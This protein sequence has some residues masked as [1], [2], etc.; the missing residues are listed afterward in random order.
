MAKKTTRGLNQSA[1]KRLSKKPRKLSLKQKVV[2]G[3][4]LTALIAGTSHFISK[5]QEKNGMEQKK[6]TPFESIESIESILESIPES[7][8]ESVP[9]SVGLQIASQSIPKQKTIVHSV[10]LPKPYIGI[11]KSEKVVDEIIKEQKLD[12]SGIRFISGEALDLMDTMTDELILEDLQQVLLGCTQSEKLH[13]QKTL[14]EDI[15][16]PITYNPLNGMWKCFNSKDKPRFVVKF[17]QR[18]IMN[19][20]NFETIFKKELMTRIGGHINTLKLLE[21]RDI[22]L[23]NFRVKRDKASKAQQ[24]SRILTD[25][26]NNRMIQRKKTENIGNKQKLD[27]LNELLKLVN[28]SQMSMVDARENEDIDKIQQEHGKQMRIWMEIRNL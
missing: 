11:S 23:K 28:E 6:E 10:I 14:Q 16:R 3:T 7:I 17:K 19:S 9:E 1:S 25:K 13:I 12:P 21:S 27:R 4:G 26:I 22:R 20:P 15:L 8:P 2:V 24:E 5:R 18:V